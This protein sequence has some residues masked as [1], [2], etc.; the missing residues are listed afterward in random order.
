MKGGYVADLP[1][2]LAAIDPCMSCTDRISLV[3]VSKGKRWVGSTDELRRH[4]KKGH[5]K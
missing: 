5:G 2:E 4:I 1:I 3:D